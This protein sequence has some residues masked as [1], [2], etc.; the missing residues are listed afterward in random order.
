MLSAAFHKSVHAISI[1][2]PPLI[3]GKRYQGWQLAYTVD[4]L[5]LLPGQISVP[6]L[7]K[8]TISNTW[9]QPVLAKMTAQNML[10]DIIVFYVNVFHAAQYKC[11]IMNCLS[12]V[13]SISSGM[14]SSTFFYDIHLDRYQ[15]QLLFKWL[16]QVTEEGK[17]NNPSEC[18]NC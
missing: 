15:Q 16:S 2:F 3:S 6:A 9:Q 1:F 12:T 17:Q 11:T 7:F 10:Q 8:P 14:I 5:H 13:R 18:R 4:V